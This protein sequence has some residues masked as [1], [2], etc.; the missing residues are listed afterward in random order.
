MGKGGVKTITDSQLLGELGETAVKKLVLEMRFIYDP[1]GR[2][3]AGTGGIIELRDP[4]S[5]APLGK[6]L[7]VQVKATEREPIHSRDARRFRI[8]AREDFEARNGGEAHK[9]RGWGYTGVPPMQ[10]CNKS[11]TATHSTLQ[12]LR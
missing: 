10:K 7:G 4:K 5:G 6:L 2:L 11:N 12:P 9:N 8:S 1:R 3:E